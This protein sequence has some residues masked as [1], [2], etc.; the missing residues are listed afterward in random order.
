MPGVLVDAREARGRPPPQLGRI[1]L[2]VEPDQT[3]AR[4]QVRAQALVEGLCVLIIRCRE[5][6]FDAT[7]WEGCS[8]IRVEVVRMLR[9]VESR[10]TRHVANA[11]ANL[12]EEA[13]ELL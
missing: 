12:T 4:S 1:G 9:V 2:Q 11:L 7:D 8:H 6:V 13:H 3:E 5:G 10:S